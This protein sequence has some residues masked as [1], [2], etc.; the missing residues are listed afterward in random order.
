MEDFVQRFWA[1]YDELLAYREQP[2]AAEPSDWTGRSTP[3]FG[4]RRATGVGRA[5]CQDPCQEG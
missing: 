1:Y 5:D 2:T 3:C 4:L